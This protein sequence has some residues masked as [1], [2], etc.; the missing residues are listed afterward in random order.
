M[1]PRR[2]RRFFCGNGGLATGFAEPLNHGR[3][4]GALLA[5]P[6]LARAATAREKLSRSRSSSTTSNG[7]LIIVRQY[8]VSALAKEPFSYSLF[9]GAPP[10]QYWK[11]SQVCRHAAVPARIKRHISRNTGVLAAWRKPERATL[12]NTKSSK[13]AERCPSSS[14]EKVEKSP[15]HPTVMMQNGMVWAFSGQ[16][17]PRHVYCGR[18]RAMIRHAS[19]NSRTW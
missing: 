7:R 16:G 18:P 11:Y 15:F 19:A 10:P 8:R 12:P 1:L 6:W 9:A 17:S 4:R 5:T 14:G 2:T 3:G 13:S